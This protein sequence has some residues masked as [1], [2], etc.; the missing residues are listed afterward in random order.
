[1]SPSLR[2]EETTPS[3]ITTKVVTFMPP[4][5]PPELPP[6]SIRNMVRSRELSVAAA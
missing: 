1:M 3:I 4:A 6:T 2:A 5:V